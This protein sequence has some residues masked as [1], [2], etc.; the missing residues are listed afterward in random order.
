MNELM[1][2]YTFGVEIEFTGMSRKRA[3]TVASVVLMMLTQ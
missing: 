2:Q 1:K 3:A